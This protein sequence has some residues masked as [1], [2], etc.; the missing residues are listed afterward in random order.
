MGGR[1]LLHRARMSVRPLVPRRL[2]RKVNRAAFR[3]VGLALR[4]TGVHCPCCGRSYRRFVDYP[5]AYCPGCGAYERHRLLCLYLDRRPELVT[6][7]VLHVGP[8]AIVI[9]R[10]GRSAK[11]WLSVDIDPQHPLVDRV[12]DVQELL[13]PDESF[14]LVICTQVLD[15]AE[16]RARGVRELHRVTRPGGVALIQAPRRDVRHGPEAYAKQLREPGFDVS[17]E[18]LPEQKDERVRRRLG[19]DDDEPIFACLRPA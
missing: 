5:S 13:L 15:L 7:D 18:W 11:S 3:V 2:Q 17:V 19:L 12:M 9:A 14:D 6:G 10:Y 16:D 1:L 4:G 8:E